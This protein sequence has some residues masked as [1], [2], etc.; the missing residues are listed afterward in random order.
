LGQGA[1]GWSGS[2]TGKLDEYER[3]RDLAATPEPAARGRG[4]RPAGAR[5]VVQEHSA[6]RL[7]WDL[8]L[9]HDGVLA[10]W[11]VPNGIP[12][13]PAQ[14]RKAIRTEDHPLEYLDFEGQIPA[15]NYGA[16]TMRIWDAGTYELEKWQ[17]KKVMI[18]FHGER[19]TGRYALFQTGADPKDWMI[20][21][22]D[23]PLDPDRESMPEEVAP[24]LARAGTLPRDDGRWAY[25]IK[26]DGVRAIAHS[27]PGRLRLSSRNAKDITERYPEVRAL[28][29]ALGSRTAILDGELVAFEPSGRPSFE[30][31]Q[32]RMNLA[33]P[34]AIRRATESE[35]VILVLFDLLYLD[36]RSLIDEPYTVRR[37]RLL[38]L[39]L[40]GPAWRT[41]AAHTGDGEAL[42]QASAEQGLEGLVAKRLDSRYEPARRSANWIKVKNSRRQEFVIGGWLPGQGRRE[43]RVGALLVGHHEDGVLRYAG[44]VGTGFT[45]DT[46]E[47]L[48]ERLAPLRRPESP[49][50]RGRLPK[51]AIF[52][53]PELVAEVEFTE[54]TAAGLLRHPSFKGLRDD[55]AAPDVV[56]EDAQR[57]SG[58]VERPPLGGG[59]APYEVLEELPR[60]GREVRIDGRTLKLSNFDK[61][62]F[63]ATGFTKGDLI[64]YYARVAPVLLAHLRGRPL[65]LKRYPD[66]VEGGHFYEKQA[67]SHRPEWVATARV[68]KVDFCLANDVPTLVWLGNLADIELHTSLA[69]A[70]A[71]ARPTMMVFD[72]DP[73]E[74]A[75]LLQCG[76]VAL[77]LRGL[78]GGLGLE[79]LVKTSGSKGLQVYVPLNTEVDYSQTRPFAKQVAE[80]LEAQMPD[81]VVSRMTKTVRRGRVFV[82]WSQNAE[83]KTTVCVYSVRARE[84]P[85]VSTPV[86]WEEVQAARAAGDP[87]ALV[88]DTTGVLERIGREGDLFA[89]VLSLVQELPRG[90]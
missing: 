16:G 19:L 50:G 66:G 46:L 64:D 4:Q 23:P 26:W 54:W 78:F 58:S 48:S 89:P 83:H 53:E 76:E 74:P 41:P 38:D 86:G 65:T 61:V 32:Q 49:F 59:A 80:A 3:K 72:L 25:E 62:L 33:S 81:L 13:D 77:V 75:G 45:E 70:D 44:R 52:C 68:G 31:L 24:M 8:R 9:E 56:R 28:N 63:P 84:R 1:P 57:D 17:A 69:L 40:E 11:A 87:E 47:T 22:I 14:N 29:R 37:E 12:E 79:S 2:L 42:L 34:T 85:T 6:T 15:G 10:S 73:G 21:R 43:Q 67:P 55:K 5:F 20:H 60:D 7:H 90:V 18:A 71:N 30:R 39:G 82:D 27:S 35:P 36:G 88:F 51:G